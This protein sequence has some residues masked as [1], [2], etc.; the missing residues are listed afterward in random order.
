MITYIMPLAW[1]VE[2]T[3]VHWYQECVTVLQVLKCMSCHK[4]IVVITVSA[5]C[6]H[7]CT[8]T[9]RTLCVMDHL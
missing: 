5:D 2:H 6:F 3:L 4:A 9:L 1:L 8:Y 7:G